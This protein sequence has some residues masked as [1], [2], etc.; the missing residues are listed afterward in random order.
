MKSIAA[1]SR[2]KVSADGHGVV[3]HAGMGLLREL[4]DR[5]GLSTQVTAALAD[6]YRGRWVYAPGEVF[7][8][9]AAAVADGADCID[10]VG[11]LCGDREHAFGAKA[12]TTTMWRLVDERIDAA[13]LPAVRCA[14]ASARAAAWA[15][16]AA[17]ITGD[18]LH[19]DIDATLVIDHSDDK[20]LAAPTWKKTYGHHPLLAFLD[21]PEIAG[22]EALAG[23]LR[24]GR[25]GSNTAADHITVL[26]QALAALPAEWRP[27][28]DQ[29]DDPDTPKVLVR[30]DT[31]GATHDFADACRAA[32]VGF[33]FGFPV[34]WRVQ[35]AV[36]TLNLGD[37]WYPAIDTNGGIRDGAWVAEA[38]GLVN[39]NSWPGGTRLILR[40]ERPHP[41]AQL[42]F[43][44]ADG[45]RVT[46]F[47]TDTPTGVVPG[48]V[49]G[50]ELRHRQ[51]ARVE[52]R[53]REL[54]NT[55]LR[56]LPCHAF[57]ANAAWLEIVLTAADLVT[58]TR[59]LGFTNHPELGRAEIA[60]FRY[61]VLHVAARI[62]HGARQVR[63]RIDA[64][65]RWAAI[66][67][68][69]WQAIRTAFD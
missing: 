5:T 9:L 56:N 11:Q 2:V 31:A 10:G 68:T 33:S 37:A 40:E 17:P 20:E 67:A 35:D 58:W 55:G 62:T 45:M 47:I 42:R 3:S 39:L 61:R 43:T 6:T 24:S 8:D 12:S 36:D 53:I 63:L 41:G 21:R 1:A 54:K 48:Q 69:A 38:T 29:R 7:A 4:A 59:L 13:R 18:W 50:L 22:G 27:H 26:D 23:M 25:A 51:H 32:G 30:C 46:A 65:W 66:I 49:A 15:A 64:T 14:R 28:P 57:D 16:G 19:I 60:T 52:D 44:D 34:D